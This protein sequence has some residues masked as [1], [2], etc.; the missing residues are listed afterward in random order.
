MGQAPSGGFD[1]CTTARDP[2][3]K[4]HRS[5]VAI[6]RKGTE[7]E[8]RFGGDVARTRS[9]TVYTVTVDGPSNAQHSPQRFRSPPNQNGFMKPGSQPAFGERQAP[10]MQPEKRFLVQDPSFRRGLTATPPP[11]SPRLPPAVPMTVSYTPSMSSP[12]PPFL[13]APPAAGAKHHYD[14]ARKDPRIEDEVRS[15]HAC[16]CVCVCVRAHKRLVHMHDFIVSFAE[17]KT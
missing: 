10:S 8:Y 1:C 6:E 16:A 13:P 7:G 12:P 11:V 14:A 15:M 17:G 5:V 4:G 2:K 9:S 3:D